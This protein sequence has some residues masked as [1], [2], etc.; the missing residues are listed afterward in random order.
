LD[1]LAK[2]T[3]LIITTVGPYMFYGEPVLAACA[4]NGTHYIDCTGEVPWYY[5]MVAKYHETAKKSGA[6]IIPQCGLDSVPA[7]LM[8]FALATHIRKT[9]N[10]PTLA[11][12]FSLYSFKT[13]V[14]G[15]TSTTILNLFSNYSLSHLAKS[16]KPYS[17]S[18]AK[19]TRAPSPVKSGFLYRLLGLP[20][21]AE[22][23][24]V[25]T[26]G[27]MASVDA[28]ITHRSWGLFE[29]FA[30]ESSYGPRFHFKEYMRAKSLI[31]GALVKLVF[32]T[33]GLVL[34]IPLTRWILSPII[35]KFFIPAPGEGPSKDKMKKDFMYYRGLAI[36]DTEKKEKV[37]GKFVCPFGAYAIT[38]L[39]MGAAAEVILR[40]NLSDTT[41]AKIG[42]GIVTPATLGEQYL[43]KL[44]AYGFQIEVGI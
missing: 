11:I 8:S 38:A 34:A 23:G 15:G 10:A 30:K 20:N 17:L 22:L 41:A 29:S 35:R 19:P 28:C 27:M 33:V 16:L 24:G 14:S 2:K 26:T 42:G 12:I 21:I 5:D 32:S 3:Q 6:I 43:E 7:D 9:L 13:G 18:P 39:T 25:Q 40:G 44:R 31:A 37:V 36:A 1:A 4:E